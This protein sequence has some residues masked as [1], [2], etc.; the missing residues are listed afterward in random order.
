VDAHWDAPQAALVEALFDHQVAQ[1]EEKQDEVDHRGGV[2]RSDRGLSTGRSGAAR[3][4]AAPVK[5]LAGC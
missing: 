3:G 4:E 5:G 2:Y 1:D